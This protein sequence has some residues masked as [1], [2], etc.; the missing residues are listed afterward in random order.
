MRMLQVIFI[1]MFPFLVLLVSPLGG[2]N[3]VHASNGTESCQKQS[4]PA[5]TPQEQW[6]WKQLCEGEIADFNQLYGRLGRLDPRK[7]EG[8]EEN[9]KLRTEDFLE[10]ILL[11][12]RYRSML[13]SDGVRIIGG[14]FVDPLDLS[15]AV[16]MHQLWLDY[17]RFECDE[18][19][20]A[21][22]GSC[23]ELS[24]L[25]TSHP[26]SFEGSKFTGPLSMGSLQASGGLFMHDAD[27]SEVDLSEATIEGQIYMSGSKFTGPLDMNG[28]QV[29]GDLFM[30]DADFS[31]VDLGGATIGGQLSMIGSKFTGPLDMNSL[32]VD[33]ALFM[34]GGTEFSEVNLGGATIGGQIDMSG[35]KFTGPLD[36]NGLQVDGDLFIGGAE[37]GEDV[38]LVLS[39]LNSGLGLSHS[40]FASLNLI[41]IHSSDAIKW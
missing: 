25:Q 24:R 26:I 29:D 12:E 31:E 2:L 35:S 1:F 6:V 11:N 9:R 17:S 36:M 4:Q 20:K 28:L 3:F 33:D 38:S 13:P 32:Q 23:V 30:H 37:F 15:N 39:D 10:A 34:R 22:F 27:F 5:W 14:W 21:E 41:P 19:V 7:P 18:R 40:T 8:W 16:L